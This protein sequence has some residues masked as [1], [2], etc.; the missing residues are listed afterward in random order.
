MG[1]ISHDINAA[2]PKEQIEEL[3]IFDAIWMIFTI[4]KVK[5]I[6]EILIDLPKE[7]IYKFHC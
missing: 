5:P 3:G 7:L 2:V 6:P 4:Q 1:H